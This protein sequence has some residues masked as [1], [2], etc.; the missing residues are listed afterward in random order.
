MVTNNGFSLT[1]ITAPDS[2]DGCVGTF[3]IS[4]LN[5]NVTVLQSIIQFV[6]TKRQKKMP[7][8]FLQS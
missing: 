7:H 8:L 2:Q 4:L 3:E 1:I 5:D 6:K